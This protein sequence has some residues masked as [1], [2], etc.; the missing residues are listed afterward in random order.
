MPSKTMD[1]VRVHKQ[2]DQDWPEHLERTREF[3]R[4]PS[5]SADGT[6]IKEMA[7]L[8]VRHL[9]GLGAQARIIPTDGHPVVYGALDC[10]A[11]K[12]LVIYGMYDVMPVTGENWMVPPFGGEIVDLPG[13]GP[14]LVN[15]GIGNSKGPL[16]GFFNVVASYNKVYGGMPVNLRFVIEGEEEQASVHLPQAIAAVRDELRR[17]D[18]V[19]FPAYAQNTRGQV[20]MRLGAKGTLHMEL[21]CQPEGQHGPRVRDVHGSEGLLITNPAWRLVHALAC[22]KSADEKMLIQDYYAEALPPNED[23]EAL[24]REL[25]QMQDMRLILEEND[26]KDFK[27]QLAGMDNLGVARHYFFESTM[28]INGLVSGY[29]GPG[30]KTVVPHRAVAKVDVRLVPNMEIE[31]T[32]KRIRAHLDRNGFG[33][34]QMQNVAGYP[35]S[36]TSV[37]EPVVQALIGAYR[38]HGKEPVIRPIMTG[39]APFYVFTRECGLPFV[40]GSLGHSER[41]HSPNEYAPVAEMKEG[42]KSQATFISLYAGW[43][44][45]R[46]EVLRGNRFFDRAT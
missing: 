40:F 6:G 9:Q 30:S 5:I 37:R 35:W 45:E 7:D 39:S 42:E 23:D 20:L 26:V 12:T 14:S 16:A 3:V 29:T 22:L 18:A 44:P 43:R 46:D 4:Q 33:D 1:P 31:P 19:F 41:H 34:I 13:F 21:V 17:C 8:L 32:V 27:A 24:M 25:C 2:I 10:G 11:P 38:F 36:K 15:R 28:N